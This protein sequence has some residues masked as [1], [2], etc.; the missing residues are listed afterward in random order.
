MLLG[1]L[2][3]SFQLF[4]ELFSIRF[5]N[6]FCVSRQHFE[7][8]LF[9]QKNQAL[10]EMFSNSYCTISDRFAKNAIWV[11]MGTLCR[12]ILFFET[13]FSRWAK[14]SCLSEKKKKK[15]GFL[16]LSLMCQRNI[17]SFGL[18]RFFCN[19]LMFSANN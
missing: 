2:G 14:I 15:F 17:L 11:K 9:F 4:D 16:K 13:F 19:F 18:F 5:Q 1:H 7:V 6:W 8:N 12:K 10:S 3:N